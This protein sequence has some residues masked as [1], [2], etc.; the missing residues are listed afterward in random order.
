MDQV[1]HHSRD[2]VKHIYYTHFP[3]PLPVFFSPEEVEMPRS[4]WEISHSV[5]MYPC[6]PPRIR[7]GCIPKHGNSISIQPSI[8][9]ETDP[10]FISVN[11]MHFI[12]SQIYTKFGSLN[13]PTRLSIMSDI[14]VIDA[15]E[16]VNCESIILFYAATMAV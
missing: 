1:V 5:W 9:A 16:N 11:T 3:P 14:S 7:P 6:D 10:A 15:L 13:K 8:V 12:N 2:T 4:R